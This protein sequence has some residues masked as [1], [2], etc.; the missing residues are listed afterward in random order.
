M[1]EEPTVSDEPLQRLYKARWMNE[2]PPGLYPRS[3]PARRYLGTAHSCRRDEPGFFYRPDLWTEFDTL[4]TFALDVRRSGKKWPERA[5]R[6]TKLA[7]STAL[8]RLEDANGALLY[9]GIS[10]DPLRRWG[11]HAGDKPW[12]PDVAHLSFEW[13]PSRTDA[14]LEEARAIKAEQPQYNIQHNAP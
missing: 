8:Y 9:V 6:S 14:L 12:W 11:E 1:R 4:E 10:D 13:H 5:P 3:L 2:V 7:T